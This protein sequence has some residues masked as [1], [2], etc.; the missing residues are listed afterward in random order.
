[1]PYRRQNTWIR[2]IAELQHGDGSWGCFHTLSAPTAARPMTTE[3]ALRRLRILGLTAEDEPIRR[4]LV[5]VRECLSGT[6]R[7]P[8]RREKAIN[9][10]AFEAHM[11]ATWLRIFVPEDP[12]AEP[13]ARMWADIVTEA[14]QGGRF[15]PDAHRRAYRERV[16]KLNSGE[17]VIGLSQFYVVNLVRGML[18]AEVEDRFVAHVIGDE[19]GILYVYDARVADLPQVF[20]SRRTSRWLGALEQL[21]VHAAAGRRLA[22]AV[23]WIR[24][25]EEDGRWDLGPSARDGVYFPISDS[26]RRGEDRRRDCTARIHRLLSRLE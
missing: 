22:F 3:Q 24:E 7:I 12:L 10:D 20:A 4:A 26:W 16:P 17:R 8:D 2:R 19:G 1:M 11:L 14:F 25:H 9:W 6:N 5:Y 23:E 21:A 18:D 15:D 13:V